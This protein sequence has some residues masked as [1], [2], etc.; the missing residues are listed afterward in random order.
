MRKGA[1]I[2]HTSP[3]P[4]DSPK[5]K[6]SSTN[7]NS[8]LTALLAEMKTLN[9]RISALEGLVSAK[10]APAAAGGG[11][12]AKKAKKEKDGASAED[13]PKR[14]PTAWVLFTGRV[15][16][17]LSEAG[18]P[19][20]DL[21]VECIMFCSSLKDENADFDSWSDADILARRAA[22]TKPEVSKA[23]TKFGPGWV[24]NK[25]WRKGSAANSV[26]SEDADGGAAPASDGEAAA[27]G[28]SH[29][30]EKKARKN[31]WEGM[32]PEEKAERIA[33]MKAGKAAKKAAEAPS[34]GEAAPASDGE[35]DGAAAASVTSSEKKKRGPKK[36]ADMTPEELEAAKA[37]RAANKAAK[38]TEAPKPSGG[39]AAAS[40]G[41]SLPALP[42]SPPASV[43]GPL[44]GFQRV[45]LS[46]APY[47][48]NLSSGHCYHR[49]A[50]GG[51]GE[52]AGIFSKTPKPHIDD[53]VPEPGADAEE[54]EELNF[55]E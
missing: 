20:K 9:G 25:A 44:E 7:V 35:A 12:P 52:W 5:T 29:P 4:S 13:K 48:V 53:S 26:V 38:T 34:D 36:F 43:T 32:T 16:S 2:Q 47:W 18:F 54:E 23:E 30:A 55:D 28:P 3:C 21:G 46:G 24:K 40:A 10:S 11:K 41:G 45:M 19:K 49:L 22:W 14:A 1:R 33:K 17:V 8:V 51:Q 27:A 39:A 15:R 6:M 50:D 42:P 37:K 31:P